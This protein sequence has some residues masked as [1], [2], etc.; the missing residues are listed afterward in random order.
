MPKRCAWVSDDPIYIEYHDKEWG[1]PLYD[2]RALFELLMLEG[3]Q[4]GLSWVTVLKKRPAYR[5]A[6][7]NFI[8]TDIAKF[9]DTKL[10]ALLKNANLIRHRLKLQAIIN[11]AIAWLELKAIHADMTQFL[12]QAVGGTP[13]KNH[14][15]N[16][17]SV[18][19]QT[20]ASI[21][22]AATLKSAGFTF[23]GP[24]ICYAFIQ[25]A[26]MVLDHTAD[27]YCYQRE[28]SD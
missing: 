26:G 24:K 6:F 27:C 25:A 11:N 22:M 19:V 4:A 20:E 5:L 17:R 3:Q 28:I 10:D 23:V 16:A 15:P 8:A 9:D 14:W 12:W 18:P 2:E 21:A 13:V 1:V 7:A